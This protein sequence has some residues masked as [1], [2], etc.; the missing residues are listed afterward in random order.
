MVRVVKS[1]P[2]ARI[3]AS[4]SLSDASFVVLIRLDMVMLKPNDN[5]PLSAQ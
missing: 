1:A 4:E 5:V 3:W 2:M